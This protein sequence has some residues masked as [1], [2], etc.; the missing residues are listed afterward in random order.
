LEEDK[1]ENPRMSPNTHPILPWY[2][3]SPKQQATLL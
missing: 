3:I 2:P 1:S